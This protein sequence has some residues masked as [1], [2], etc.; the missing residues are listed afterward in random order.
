M[1]PPEN[2]PK[3]VPY[4]WIEAEAA[5]ALAPA[6]YWRL[7]LTVEPKNDEVADTS[8]EAKSEI[9]DALEK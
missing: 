7:A 1:N 4:N 3:S 5:D 2:T 8:K 9:D 6:L